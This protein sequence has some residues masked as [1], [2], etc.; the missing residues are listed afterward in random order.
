MK[1]LIIESGKVIFPDYIAEDV[2]VVCEG[3]KILEIVPSSA[4]IFSDQD[5]RID[6]SGQYVSPGF[7][8]IHLHGGG[9][10]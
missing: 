9:G 7:I 4:V 10:A 3:G 2:S 1:R 6:A 5:V 8:D